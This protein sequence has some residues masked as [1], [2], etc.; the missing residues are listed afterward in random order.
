MCPTIRVDEQVYKW[1]Q[2]EAIPFHDT[3]NSV[4]RR[5][6]GLG[7]DGETGQP[8]PRDQG[9]QA[10]AQTA[11]QDI[12]IDGRRARLARGDHLIPRWKIPARQARFRRDGTWFAPLDTFPAALCDCKGYLVLETPNDLNRYPEHLS[13]HPS[14]QITVAGG[15]FA[16][17][18]YVKVDDPIEDPYTI[19]FDSVEL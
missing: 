3:P 16:I 1:L 15:I 8:R 9:P 11:A 4:L 12:H 19:D 14:G 5:I 18:G 6:A 17:P 13:V 10:P 7:D 2:S